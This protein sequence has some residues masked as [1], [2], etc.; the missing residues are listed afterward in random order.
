MTEILEISLHCATLCYVMFSVFL[1]NLDGYTGA[2]TIQYICYIVEE[3]CS[4]ITGFQVWGL[5]QAQ[6][7]GKGFWLC[8]GKTALAFQSSIFDF[9]PFRKLSHTLVGCLFVSPLR[10][11]CFMKQLLSSVHSSSITVFSL[12]PHCDN[13]THLASDGDNEISHISGSYHSF[14][15][16]QLWLTEDTFAELS[17]AGPSSGNPCGFGKQVSSR[18]FTGQSQLWILSLT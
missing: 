6:K 2:I 8:V 11:S 16:H 12:A 13:W 17:N 5:A 14:F 4:W 10:T 1:Q 7:L 3:S 18:P 9:F 15:Y